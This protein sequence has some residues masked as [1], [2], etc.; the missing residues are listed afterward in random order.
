MLIKERTWRDEAG[1]L[2]IL[3]L[4]IA[5]ILVF[6]VVGILFGGW[7]DIALIR[8]GFTAPPV[9]WIAHL[10]GFII[11]VGVTLTV[12]SRVVNGEYWWR[13]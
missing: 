7:L 9:T 4:G 5:L 10:V 2:G 3:C 12:F 1:D 8:A 13:T 11:T 6:T